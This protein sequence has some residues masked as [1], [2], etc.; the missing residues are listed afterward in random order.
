VIP[1]PAAAAVRRTT[2]AGATEALGA[3]LAPALAVGDVVALSGPLGA[4][5]TRLAV[6]V[7]RGLRVASRVRSPS[8]T[9][10]NEYAGRLPL[11]HLDLYRLET[12]AVDG[13]GLEELVERGVLVVEWADRL[14][15]VWF[16]Q[17]L[18]I[19]IGID[20]AGTRTFE[21]AATSGRGLELLA[22][23]RDLPEPGALA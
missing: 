11:F 4:G 15:A 17:A 21:A 5:K 1:E 20:E 8:F 12:G 19:R 13:L 6:G 3:L 2:S 14:P 18:E 7:A 10:V 22:A 23:W 9:L 16:E